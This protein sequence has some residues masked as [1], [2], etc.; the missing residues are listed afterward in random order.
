MPSHRAE[1]FPT[2]HPKILLC[3]REQ[4]GEDVFHLSSSSSLAPSLYD[5]VRHANTAA[6]VESLQAQLKIREGQGGHTDKKENK[7][8]LINKEIQSGAVAKSYMK[9]GFLIHEEMRK[10]LVI[11]EEAVSHL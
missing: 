4:W 7:I 6:V 1:Y 10:Y 11:Y 2:F 8:F 9:K 5:T 3:F